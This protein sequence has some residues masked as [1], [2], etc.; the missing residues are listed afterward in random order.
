MCLTIKHPQSLAAL[1][2]GDNNV[3]LLVVVLYGFVRKLDGCHR[4]LSAPPKMSGSLLV[5]ADA[6]GL[7]RA[8]E[9]PQQQ[10]GKPADSN[11][12]VCP[13]QRAGLCAQNRELPES[14]LAGAGS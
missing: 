9:V 5:T 6:L 2:P 1:V 10:P 3:S 13:Q 14:T 11:A 4:L 12:G 8:Q 7:P